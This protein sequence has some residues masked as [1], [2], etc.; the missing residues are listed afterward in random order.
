MVHTIF[1]KQLKESD[2]GWYKTELMWK[3]GK[4]NL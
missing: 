3:Q 1:K 4:E 2:E